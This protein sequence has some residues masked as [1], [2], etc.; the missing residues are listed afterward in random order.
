MIYVSKDGMPCHW[1]ATLAE[2]NYKWQVTVGWA[3]VVALV[4]LD[5]S[6]RR[7]PTGDRLRLDE[8]VPRHPTGDQLRLAQSVLCSHTLHL[9][10]ASS[11]WST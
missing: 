3:S 2:L 10:S 4:R 9:Q 5:E 1:V 6:V 7:H 8:T 11:S